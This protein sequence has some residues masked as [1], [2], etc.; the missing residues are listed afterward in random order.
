MAQVAD[1]YEH[2]VPWVW[3]ESKRTWC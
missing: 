1:C 3:G 2:G